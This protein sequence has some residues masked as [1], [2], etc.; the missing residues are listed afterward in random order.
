MSF[1]MITGEQ[2]RTARL[3]ARR[4]HGRLRQ[5]LVGELVML[6]FVAFVR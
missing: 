3:L 6:V 1:A 4:A 5:R 2:Q